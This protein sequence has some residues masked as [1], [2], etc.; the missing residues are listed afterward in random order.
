MK[1]TGLFTVYRY[2][3][4]FKHYGD[5][6]KIVPFGDVHR[7]A[8]LHAEKIWYKFIERYKNDPSCYFIGMGDYMDELST[9][10]RKSF[11]NS[12]Y[13]DSTTQNLTKFYSARALNFAKEISFMKNRIIGFCEGNHYFA[14]QDGTTTTNLLCRELEAKYL[15]VKCFIDLVLQCD[16]HHSSRVV[17]CCHHGESGGRRITTSIGKLELMA[18]T[19]DAEIILQGHD[20]RKNH[21]EVPHIGITHSQ[22]GKP[23]VYQKTKYCARTGGFLKGYVDQH[24]S[25]IADANL[26]PNDL[27]NVEFHLVPKMK[28]T[29]VPVLKVLGKRHENKS[30]EQRWVNIEFHSCNYAE[31]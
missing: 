19:H 18:F 6:I 30:S 2:V 17:I 20:H 21:I 31:H 12:D 28:R 8:P 22:K 16:E 4:P 24:M 29:R 14:L 26:P 11:I 7:F 3:I 13:H 27:G 15:G 5:V 10:E 1:T 23:N 25:Y 9:S